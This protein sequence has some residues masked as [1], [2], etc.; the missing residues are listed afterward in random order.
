MLDLALILVFC[1]LGT[2]VG[3]CTGLLPGLHVNNI[4]LI[5]LSLSGTIVAACAPLLSY[6]ISEQFVLLLIAGFIISVSVSHTFHDVLPTTFIG[7]PE[8]DTA[9]SVL[10]AHNLLLAGLG[11]KAIALSALGSYGAIVVCLLFI[12]P[13]RFII[14]EPL[15]LYSAL[16]GVMA[17][18]L[19]AITILMIATEKAKIEDFGIKGKTPAIAGMLFA[20]FVFLLS[21]IFGLVVL[22]LPVES[23]VGLSAPV[24]FPALAGL[25]GTPTLLNSVMTKP[26]IPDQKIEP[27][28]LSKEEKKSSILSIFSGSL[29]GIIV[30]II[31]GITSSTG[32]IL[33]MNAREGSGNEQTIVTLSSVNTASS[34]S[35]ILVL[36]IILRPRS[37]AAIA[38]NELIPVEEWTTLMI[39][40]NFL[41]LL[42]FLVLAGS[43]SYFL[44]IAIG[45]LF[46]R[47]F[48]KIPYEPLVWATIGLVVFLVFLFTG[49]LGIVVL[50]AATCI[51]FLPICWGVRRSHCMGILLIPIILHFL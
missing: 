6:G 15:L 42:I 34:F 41:F 44:T 13:I 30:S 39:P 2:L 10:P 45:K 32:T 1:I 23:P 18:V 49:F 46:A 26:H 3:V 5:L 28:S 19:I 12:Y 20:L 4:A 35:V 24:L 38:V 50:M 37:G 27:L 36:F 11:Y 8:E 7:A 17:F 29:A 22:D 43:L 14:G 31:P 33:A 47:K 9:L 21:G 16:Q 48:S 25:F 51:G 40:T